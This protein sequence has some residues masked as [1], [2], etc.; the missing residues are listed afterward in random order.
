MYLM[1]DKI[2]KRNIFINLWYKKDMLSNN[3]TIF[4]ISS[5]I[6]LFTYMYMIYEYE[7]VCYT[8]GGICERVEASN[9]YSENRLNNIWICMRYFVNSIY[10]YTSHKHMLHLGDYLFH[11]ET[12]FYTDNTKSSSSKRKWIMRLFL[13][14]WVG[15][16]STQK[17]DGH[18]EVLWGRFFGQWDIP[19]PH[20]FPAFFGEFRCGKLRA[21]DKS[22]TRP[23]YYLIT[24]HRLPFP[25]D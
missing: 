24:I 22:A 25:G 4:R 21:E 19:P 15:R 2:L 3:C 11:M 10:R 23:N 12:I 16:G 17:K 5:S 1:F 20:N 8:Y 7:H 13:N 18:E 6:Y 9:K 14:I